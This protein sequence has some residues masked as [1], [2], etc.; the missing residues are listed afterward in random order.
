MQDKNILTLEYLD[1]NDRLADLINAFYFHGHT[2]VSGKDIIE[3]DSSVRNILKKRGKIR[4]QSFAR[5]IIRKAALGLEYVIIGI[6][7]QTSIDRTMPVRIMSYDAE[8]YDRQIRK[9]KKIHRKRNDLKKEEFL[10]GIAHSDY[11]LPVLTS[12]I[13]FG[14]E[15]WSGPRDL[16]GLLDLN[17]N[18]AH[19]KDRIPNY[20]IDILEV[21]KFPHWQT[22]KSD[23]KQVFGYLQHL[24]DGSTL[25][26]FL[27]KYR[28]DFENLSEDTFNLL[29]ELTNAK[30]LKKT[31]K[32]N[33]NP[34]GGF[35]MC[36][37]IQELIDN[38]VM[39]GQMEGRTEGRTEILVSIICKKLNQGLSV[40]SISYWMEL[41]PEYVNAIAAIRA[42]HPNYSNTQIALELLNKEGKPD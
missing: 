31:K 19:L 8:T 1:D 28:H 3:L 40:D 12:V 37:A 2:V 27:D 38:G 41:D 22:F 20:T 5:D 32:E 25:M 26:N 30:E 4:S 34:Q 18:L 17:G 16:H 35:N 23:L 36:K 13:Y 14:E 24:Q 9:L 15:S 21:R 7:H 33:Q 39:R 6:E 29:S 10:S 11:L 42:K